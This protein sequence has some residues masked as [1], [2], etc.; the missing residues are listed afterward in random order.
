MRQLISA[1]LLLSLAS[2]PLIGADTPAFADLPTEQFVLADG[3]TLVGRYNDLIEQLWIG[4][5]GGVRITI[6]TGDIVS[7]KPYVPNKSGG[8]GNSTDSKSGSGASTA[9]PDTLLAVKRDEVEAL[10]SRLRGLTQNITD[11][12]RKTAYY[13]KTVKELSARYKELLEILEKLGPR[14]LLGYEGTTTYSLRK[15]QTEISQAATSL[16]QS[17]TRLATLK[18]KEPEVTE[19]L[20]KAEE[21]LAQ[22]TQKRNPAATGATAAAKAAEEGPNPTFPPDANERRMQQLE[23]QFR[24][25]QRE[26]AELQRSYRELQGQRQMAPAPAPVPTTPSS[27]PRLDSPFFPAPVVVVE[28]KRVAAR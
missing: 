2:F 22:L 26:H 12:T 19:Q 24:A 9:S 18:A 11:E 25:L 5:I 6:K 28:E 4:G 16:E 13:S 3:R 21:E 7:R 20:A 17:E 10:K 15:A 1:T 23:A 8:P 27:A 14:T